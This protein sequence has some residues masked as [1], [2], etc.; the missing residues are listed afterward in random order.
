MKAALTSFVLALLVAYVAGTSY[1]IPAD[2]G[3]RS[4]C[5]PWDVNIV[6]DIL[7]ALKATKFC[8][9]W[10]KITTSTTTGGSTALCD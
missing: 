1:P 8:T 9:S 10:L 6:Y 2:L 4:V 7:S 3:S 5:G